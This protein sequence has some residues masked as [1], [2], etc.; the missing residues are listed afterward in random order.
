[1]ETVF[2]TK[3]VHPR[4]RFEFWH[5]VACVNLVGHD[6]RTD[7]PER[8]QASLQSGTVDDLGI[9]R[10]TNS[11][12][13]ASRDPSHVSQASDDALFLCHQLSGAMEVEQNS[14]ATALASGATT[15]ID[16]MLPYTAKFKDGSTLLVVKLP[17]REIEARIGNT[18]EIICRLPKK[19]IEYDLMSDLVSKMPDL[20]GCL[21][22]TS[23]IFIR[24]QM[25]D[26][27]SI[28][29]T[30][31]VQGAQISS[32]KSVALMKIR[33]VVESRLSDSS[34]DAAEIAANAGVSVR[35]ATALM[36]EANTSIMRFVLGRRLARCKE[37]LSDPHQSHRNISEI[38]YSWGFSDMTHFGRRFRLA[39]GVL[40]REYRRLKS[41]D[42]R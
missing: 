11:F 3:D 9:V 39:Y 13:V 21:A 12:M 38:A 19:S 18:R 16:P 31:S 2:S 20:T 25:L 5:D 33:A 23:A 14:R 32:A 8:F 41:D 34:L 26:L 24:N 37:A 35:Y 36:K 30:M 40:P 15:L 6:S 4:D 42:K 22:P 29:L 28:A 27:V 10:F 7:Y 17:R 1:V